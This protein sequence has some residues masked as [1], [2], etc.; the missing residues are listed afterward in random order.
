MVVCCKQT[1]IM[2][3]LLCVLVLLYWCC[4][5]ENIECSRFLVHSSAY[6]FIFFALC[7]NSIVVSMGPELCK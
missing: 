7:N 2:G 4:N 3:W 5:I 1:E 6:F